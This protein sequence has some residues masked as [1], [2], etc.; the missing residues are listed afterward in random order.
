MGQTQAEA[1]IG[2]AKRDKSNLEE[3]TS[4]GMITPQKSLIFVL[5]RH[6]YERKDGI[7][8]KL[9]NHRQNM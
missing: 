6:V 1:V 5:A 9:S 3:F 4:K 8:G 7:P 2:G